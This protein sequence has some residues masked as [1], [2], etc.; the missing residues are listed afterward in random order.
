MFELE[1]HDIFPYLLSISLLCSFAYAYATHVNKNAYAFMEGSREVSLLLPILPEALW[2][3][4]PIRHRLVRREKRKESPDDDITDCISSFVRASSYKR[5]GFL[6]K[7]ATT[8]GS[9]S[10]S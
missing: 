9:L 8:R 4:I 7:Q 10:L 2:R 6:C 5:G 1:W 3:T